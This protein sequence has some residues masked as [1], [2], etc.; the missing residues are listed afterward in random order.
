MGKIDYRKYTPSE[1]ATIGWS[2]AFNGK[3]NDFEN[4]IESLHGFLN[5]ENLI[6]SVSFYLS[7]FEMGDYVV[8]QELKDEIESYA[9]YNEGLVKQLIDIVLKKTR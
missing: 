4:I 8:T 6:K 2:H 5:Y 7:G 3:Q 1:L 9:K